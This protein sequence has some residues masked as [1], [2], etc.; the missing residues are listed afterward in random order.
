M[1]ELEQLADLV[2]ALLGMPHTTVGIEHVPVAAADALA[3]EI[4]GLH[5]V[6]DY[7][8]SRSLGYA[9][10][11]CDVTQTCVGLPVESQQDLRVA[12]EEVPRT[13]SRFRT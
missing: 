1:E 3:F 12:R 6:V 5:E 13:A 8:L 2:L 4:P 7:P 11:V 10:R 9:N